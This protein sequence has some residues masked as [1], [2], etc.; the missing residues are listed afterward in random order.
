LDGG[1]QDPTSFGVSLNSIELKDPFVICDRASHQVTPKIDNRTFGTI[2]IATPPIAPIRQHNINQLVPLLPSESYPDCLHISFNQ[3]TNSVIGDSSDTSSQINQEMDE[4]SDDQTHN[5]DRIFCDYER[6][7][8]THLELFIELSNLE[9]DEKLIFR[10]DRHL[11]KIRDDF[12]NDNKTEVLPDGRRRF[13][14][15]GSTQRTLSH[16]SGVLTLNFPRIRDRLKNTEI[17][18]ST[19][20]IAPYS[21]RMPEFNDLLMHLRLNGTKLELL[22][23]VAKAMAGPNAVGVSKS[24]LGKN[25]SLLSEQIENFHARPINIHY[26]YIYADASYFTIKHHKTKI[27]VIAFIGRTIDFET[28]I[29]DFFV[30]DGEKTEEWNKCFESMKTRGLKE[31][32]III[33]DGNTALWNSV[34]TQFPG[35]KQQQCWV[36]IA[37]NIFK[38]LDKTKID[39][40]EVSEMLK[41]IYTANSLSDAIAR[42]SE[43]KVK[44][45]KYR[46]AIKCLD[47]ANDRLFSFF[48]FPTHIRPFLYTS[49]LIESFFSSTKNYTDKA[50]GCFNLHTLLTAIYYYSMK[51]NKTGLTEQTALIR[52]KE[53]VS[54]IHT[55]RI[56]DNI[57]VSDTLPSELNILFLKPHF[58]DNN[59][60][61]SRII[62]MPSYRLL[63]TF[64]GLSFPNNIVPD[65]KFNEVYSSISSCCL[66]NKIN[67]S[68]F[69]ES[70]AMAEINQLFDRIYFH[71][72]IVHFYPEQISLLLSDILTDTVSIKCHDDSVLSNITPMNYKHIKLDKSLLFIIIFASLVMSQ[73][74]PHLKIFQIY[75][76]QTIVSLFNIILLFAITQIICWSPCSISYSFRL[77]RPPPF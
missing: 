54:N 75:A 76:P 11:K 66:Y 56:S 68:K 22:S 71:D 46:K 23:M 20:F 36:H 42:L 53:N 59:D 50:K 7:D 19:D 2:P 64:F 41:S 70:N 10:L 26:R 72:N 74:S 9:R 30:V 13:V 37:R 15:G 60:S 14:G 55:K 33:G 73:H 17:Q 67:I 8:P 27:C 18:F 44:Y 65:F 25:I 29:I 48:N 52:T 21:R 1:Y 32:E 45:K 61:Q 28:E 6:D 35:T 24:A 40:N 77:P 16:S 34:E 47:I 69:S 39:I 31:P 58:I 38:Y 57:K 12:L 62:S 43:F 5:W 4:Q 51:F 3:L 49:N 63:P